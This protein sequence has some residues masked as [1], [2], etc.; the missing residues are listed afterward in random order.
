MRT[1]L[2]N[3]FYRFVAFCCLWFFLIKIRI[4]TSTRIKAIAFWKDNLFRF[5]LFMR[6]REFSAK[7]WAIWGRRVERLS[8]WIKLI[9][10]DENLS[11]WDT[12]S[13]I[14]FKIFRGWVKWNFF[15]LVFNSRHYFLSHMR[16][17]SWKM[18][19]ICWVNIVIRAVRL[20][21]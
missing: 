17:M 8:I 1:F 19:S 16:F 4:V 2:S 14:L 15:F 6:I 7:L 3:S 20:C 12:L 11:L 5:T 21:F 10:L 13:S 9:I 18:F